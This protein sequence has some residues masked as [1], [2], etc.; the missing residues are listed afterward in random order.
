MITENEVA[1]YQLDRYEI[2]FIN[3]KI[4]NLPKKVGDF[5]KALFFEGLEIFQKCIDDYQ[6]KV[7]ESYVDLISNIADFEKTPKTSE[8]TTKV[9]NEETITRNKSKPSIIGFIRRSTFY[10]NFYAFWDNKLSSK[11]DL[12]IFSIENAVHT[13]YPIFVEEIKGPLKKSL[14]I[15]DYLLRIASGEKLKWSEFQFNKKGGNKYITDIVKSIEHSCRDTRYLKAVIEGLNPPN[16]PLKL[17]FLRNAGA[18]SNYRIIN[19][20]D[21]IW[22]EIAQIKEKIPAMVFLG[23]YSMTID[24]IVMLNIMIHLGYRRLEK[25][26]DIKK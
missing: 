24:L 6:S 4:E 5:Q 15:F 3:K 13:F 23:L 21:K 1:K 9:Y 7:E 22:I 12:E 25:F 26:K 18:H 8:N 11:E 20:N 2:N 19:Q 17:M 14:L 10:D 16:D